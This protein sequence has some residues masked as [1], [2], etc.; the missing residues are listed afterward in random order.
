MSTRVPDL[1]LLAL[2]VTATNKRYTDH[3][4]EHQCQEQRW[5]AE[6]DEADY[7]ADTAAFAYGNARRP[8]A[9]AQLRT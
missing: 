6:R 2:R 4:D 7:A 8:R 9:L 5:C 3:L 1:S